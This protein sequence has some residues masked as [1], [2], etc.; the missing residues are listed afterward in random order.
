[1]FLLDIYGN[2]IKNCIIR[3]MSYLPLLLN[4]VLQFKVAL[5]KKQIRNIEV[6]LI[7]LF[8]MIQVMRKIG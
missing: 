5:K 8:Q 4:N 2:K 6:K 7:L 3:L 1:M